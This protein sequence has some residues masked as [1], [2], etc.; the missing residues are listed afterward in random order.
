MYLY[1]GTNY[2]SAINIVESGVDFEKCDPLTD[3]GRGFYLS[4]K[5]EF[6]DRRA[7][8]MET[9]ASRAAVVEMQYDEERANRELKVLRFA[10]GSMDWQFFVAFN[11]TGPEYFETMNALFPGKRNNLSCMY[12]VV[13]DI[14]ADAKI[15][16]KTHEIE[17]VLKK[18]SESKNRITHYK[19]EVIRLIRSISIGDIDPQARQYSFHTQQ[20][21]AYL[22]DARIIETGVVY[23]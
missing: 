13:I 22:R 14:P 1:H 15:S 17:S 10:D 6:A 8:Y 23:T 3:N 4:E 11:R 19:K 21:L 12:D 5:K 18:V 20:S 16:L 2:I 9:S 7:H